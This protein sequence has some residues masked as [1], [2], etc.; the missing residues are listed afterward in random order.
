MILL[1]GGRG[2]IGSAFSRRFDALNVDYC[3]ISRSQVDYTR[4]NRLIDL[5]KELKPAFLINAAGY[6]GKPNVDACE[7]HKADCLLGNAVLPGIIREACEFCQLPWGHVSSGCIYNG[8]S[9]D[10]RGFRELDPPNFCFRSPPCSFY[11]GSKALGEEC[12][13]DAEQVFVWRLRIPFNHIDCDRNYLSKLMR[14]DR[15]LDV[16]NSI[17]HLDEFVDACLQSWDL[18]IPFGVYNM[19]NPGEITT[20]EVVGL[21]RQTLKPDRQFRFFINETEFME[22]VAQTPRSTCVLNVEKLLA[23]GIHMRDV[24]DAVSA[25]L[26]KWLPAHTNNLSQS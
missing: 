15:L 14:Y 20:H 5:I 13:Q 6:T 3:S 1:L 26:G 19:T 18:R 11:S 4:R 24:R 21:I 10:G 8:Q 2:Y 23:A 22:T 12:L 7:K 17:T 25:A 9:A 16:A